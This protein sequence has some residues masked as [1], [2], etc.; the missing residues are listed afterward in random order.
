MICW[1]IADSHD[2]SLKRNDH[3]II[4]SP[5][6]DIVSSPSE[7]SSR[8]FVLHEGSKVSV[9]DQSGDWFEVK[10]PNGNSGWIKAS[11]LELI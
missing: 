10:L 4:M 2:N 6:V 11:E 3:G 7:G 1:F 9:E 5:T 8:L